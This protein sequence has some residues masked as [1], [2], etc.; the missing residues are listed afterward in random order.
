MPKHRSHPAKPVFYA[1]TLNHK[2]E[3][4]I[5]IITP[6]VSYSFG[7]TSTKSKEMNITVPMG[8]TSY[9]YQS[10]Q[11]F[12]VRNG[13]TRYQVSAGTNDGGEPVASLYGYKGKVLAEIKL[14][15]PYGGE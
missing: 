11:G 10:N 1:Q 3:V 15:P 9:A 8:N 6:S 5:C 14:A 4:E 2:K 7:K 12:T 13:D